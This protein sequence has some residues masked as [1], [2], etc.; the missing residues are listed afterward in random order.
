MT[1][2]ESPDLSMAGAGA[3]NASELRSTLEQMRKLAGQEIARLNRKLAERE[4][5]IARTV[6]SATE[7]QAMLQDLAVLQHALRER[8]KTLDHITA[9]C[10]RL[11]DAL[12]DQHLA[13]DGLRQQVQL[14]DGSLKA[15][16]EEV[17]RLKRQLAEIQEHSVD[18][19]AGVKRVLSADLPALPPVEP[20]PPPGP[21]QHVISFSAGLMSGLLVLGIAAALLW[22]GLDLDLSGLWGGSPA[23]VSGPTEA[24]PQ[25]VVDGPPSAAPVL[26][27][28]SLAPP[29]TPPPTRRDQL[30][31]GSLGPTLAEFQGGR[32]RMGQNSL[33]GADTG[34]ERD[35]RVLPFLIGLYEVTYA[36]YD[37]F[38]R[39]TGRR[40]PDD[41]G[42]GRGDRPAV[43]V[44]WPEAVAYTEWL[45][46]QTGKPYRLPSEAEWE[47]AARGGGR[48]SFW[49]GFAP[50]AG[51]AVCFDCGSQWDNRSTAPVGRFAPNPYGLF[52]ITGNAQEWVADCYFPGYDGA[53]ADSR[54]RL[55]GDCAHRVARGGAFNKPAAS[56]RAFARARFAPETRLNLLGFRVARDPWP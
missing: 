9:E 51:R 11:E 36:Q 49:W 42:W 46:R 56:M 13:F 50:E 14:K 27:P 10:R 17:Q 37:R 4:D 32:F 22:G 53:P 3:S 29:A 23:P 31:D 2:P 25:V 44:S 52:D 47:F 7:R 33:S 48:S 54:P 15:A 20:D 41:F 28:A 6:S 24:P 19:S 39:A 40:L 26:P 43:G 18:P 21:A 16:R 1:M 12:E 55:D 30:R 34:P 45:S 5:A 38:A 35:V 8:E